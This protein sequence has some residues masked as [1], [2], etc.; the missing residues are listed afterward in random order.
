[1]PILKKK[2]YNRDLPLIIIGDFNAETTS[3]VAQHVLSDKIPTNLV[4]SRDIAIIKNDSSG[5]F[6]DFGK[7][8][9][10]QRE[11]IDYFSVR[12]RTQ[13]LE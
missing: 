2:T 10:N 8:P 5:T 11:Y 1:M 12:K 4:N 3:D 9:K 13:V 6:R 7:L